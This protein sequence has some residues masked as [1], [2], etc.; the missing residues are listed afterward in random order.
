VNAE[1]KQQGL[2]NPP[3]D[4]MDDISQSNIRKLKKMGRLLVP[5]IRRCRGRIV[6]G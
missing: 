3:D 6:D 4:A 1:M 5:A 2:A